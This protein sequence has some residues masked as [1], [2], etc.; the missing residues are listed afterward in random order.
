[1]II[2]KKCCK[3]LKGRVEKCFWPQ[4]K[5]EQYAREILRHFDIEKYFDGVYGASMDETLVKKAD[6]LNIA[7]KKDN[8]DVKKALMV[9]DR[10]HDISGA[11]EVGMDSLFLELGYANEEEAEMLS[12]TATYRASNMKEL[13][14]LFLEI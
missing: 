11:E 14:T 8:V 9:G 2:L 5:P 7:V 12:K 13:C 6:I 3:C 10:V 1:M 4:A